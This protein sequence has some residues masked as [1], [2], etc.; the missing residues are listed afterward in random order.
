MIKKFEEYN[1]KSYW[2]IDLEEY[3]ETFDDP[4]DVI[5][6]KEFRMILDTI[7]IDIIKYDDSMLSSCGFLSIQTDLYDI[8]CIKHLDEWFQVAIWNNNKSDDRSDCYKCDQIVGVLDCIRDFEKLIKKNE[9]NENNSYQSYQEIP[10]WE[11]YRVYDEL[12]QVNQELLE[13]FTDDEVVEIC[14]IVSQDPVAS[15]VIDINDGGSEEGFISLYHREVSKRISE[16]LDITTIYIYR[17]KDEWF[18]VCVEDFHDIHATKMGEM[19]PKPYIKF[20]KCDQ[21]HGLSELLKKEIKR[22]RTF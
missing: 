22:F 1:Y 12:G 16:E 5:T 2:S 17:F 9:V 6:D 8:N 4:Y 18:Y 19:V 11:Y 14:N 15:M 3:N 20:Y 10:D 7:S 21:L 13:E